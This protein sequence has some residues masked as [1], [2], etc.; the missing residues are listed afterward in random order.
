MKNS[1]T[2]KDYNSRVNKILNQLRAYR[3]DILERKKK[4][5]LKFF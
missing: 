2:V 5:L 4:K 1:E 3:D